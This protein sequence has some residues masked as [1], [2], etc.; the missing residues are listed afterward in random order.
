M[1]KYLDKSI[2][3]LVI[4]DVVQN[5]YTQVKNVSVKF[6]LKTRPSNNINMI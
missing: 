3:E 5:I 2:R 1:I 6:T 4:N